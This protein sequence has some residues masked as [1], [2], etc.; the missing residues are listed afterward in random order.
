MAADL[1]VACRLSMVMVAD[2]FANLLQVAWPGQRPE[3]MI[4][5]TTYAC[6]GMLHII[7]R[8]SKDNHHQLTVAI[9]SWP[10]FLP[11]QTSPM[12]T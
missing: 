4:M 1:H 6:I 11:E 8:T 3:R 12:Q 10:G 9:S 5:C 2:A 7:R